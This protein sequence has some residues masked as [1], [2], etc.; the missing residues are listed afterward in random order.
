MLFNACTSPVAQRDAGSVKSLML[1][2]II[3]ASTQVFTAAGDPP[4]SAEQWVAVG[5]AAEELGEAARML[6]QPETYPADSEWAR[7]TNALLDASLRLE[8]AV[9]ERQETTLV[10]AGDEAY[11]S[12]EGCH[13]DYLKAPIRAQ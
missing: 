10:A 9:R 1:E 3:P 4:V 8:Q 12:C 6:S 5:R 13:Q 7:Q 2:R 11:A